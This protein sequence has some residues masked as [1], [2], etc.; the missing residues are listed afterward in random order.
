MLAD[1]KAELAQRARKPPD[2][3]LGPSGKLHQLDGHDSIVIQAIVPTGNTP[4]DQHGYMTMAFLN[5]VR[6]Q[7]QVAPMGQ[8]AKRT[9]TNKDGSGRLFVPAA[10]HPLS[11]R[12]GFG[13][14]GVFRTVGPAKN[15][16]GGRVQK[17]LAFSDSTPTYR[18]RTSFHKS[19]T[20]AAQ[21]TLPI[22]MRQALAHALRTARL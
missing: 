5:R 17:V 16:S 11:Q 14:S 12:R 20:K 9:K 6:S 1:I 13:S 18:P 7:L 4:L 15:R 8:N 2:H 3:A 19:L 10:D 22:K 21:Q